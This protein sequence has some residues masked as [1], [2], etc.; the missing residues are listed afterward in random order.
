[1][2]TLAE[3][4]SNLAKPASLPPLPLSIRI[5]KDQLQNLFPFK[6]LNVVIENP[7]LI[8]YLIKSKS[9]ISFLTYSKQRK[10]LIL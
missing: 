1:M 9:K 3:R 5:R 10:L 8:P 2:F 4:I 6:I 7:T